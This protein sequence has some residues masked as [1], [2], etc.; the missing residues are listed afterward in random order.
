MLRRLGT[1]LGSLLLISVAWCRSG[2]SQE[3]AVSLLLRISPADAEVTVDEQPVPLAEGGGVALAQVTPGQHVI[4]VKEEGHVTL[5][6]IVD[7]ATAGAEAKVC[8]APMVTQVVV[9]MKSGRAIEGGLLSREGDRITIT[10]GKGKMTLRKGQYEKLTVVGEA[11]LGKST[12]ELIDRSRR[13]APTADLSL[14]PP[15]PEGTLAEQVKAM[16]ERCETARKILDDTKRLYGDKAPA[17]QQLE[18]RQHALLAQAAEVAGRIEEAIERAEQIQQDLL[19][20][21]LAKDSRVVKAAA[22]DVRSHE[23]LLESLEAY[24]PDEETEATDAHAK[25]GLPEGLK[26]AFMVPRK[27]SDQYRNSVV[28][29]GRRKS[30]RETGLPYEIWLKKPRM[31]FVL[32]PAGEFM[33]GSIK[34]PD[35]L[36]KRYGQARDQFEREHP[37]HLVRITKSLYLSKY[38]MTQTQWQEV[39][40]SSPWAG[41]KGVREGLRHPACY[42]TWRKS[43]EFIARLNKQL[44]LEG[45]RLPSEAEWE[46]ACR[47]GT[48]TDFY[49]GDDATK[50]VKYA[51]CCANTTDVGE[52]YAHEIGTKLP[53]AWGLYDMHGNVYEWCQDWLGGYTSDIQIDP[54]GPAKGGSRVLRSCA[55]AW[56]PHR[57]R[58]AYRYRWDPDDPSV[59][60]T[61]RLV[62]SLP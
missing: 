45:F 16:R 38:E 25:R 61:I 1:L 60:A 59:F 55:Y 27:R 50:L 58:T 8:L 56:T 10:R 6:K 22:D 29:R 21:G 28:R 30:D 31:E 40:V 34:S 4:V 20:K 18:K 48:T 52:K 17:A 7:V 41:R 33:M 19:A 46:Y 15:L 49:F 51:W 26:K 11:P 39:M 2:A 43:Q 32:I 42:I 47:A 37:R 14:A 24:L 13:T 62:A 57:Q 54:T 53:N 23:A 12:L 36:A 3:G 5:R 44:R 9:Q 35:E